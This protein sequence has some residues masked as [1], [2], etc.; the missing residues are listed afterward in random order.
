MIYSATNHWAEV[1]DAMWCCSHVGLISLKDSRKLEE[2]EGY[3]YFF[4]TLYVLE[5]K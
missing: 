3:N 5:S 1:H 2:S 4:L